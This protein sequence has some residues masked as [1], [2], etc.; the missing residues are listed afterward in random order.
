[1]SAPDIFLCIRILLLL[2]GCSVS[3]T[4][5]LQAWRHINIDDMANKNVLCI[6]E[7]AAGFMYFGTHEGV[8]VFDGRH[9]H[10]VA[11]RGS[12][13]KGIFNPFVNS[14]KWGRGGKLWV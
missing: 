13:Q 8:Q 12:V 14:M 2:T 10:Q 4:A 5:Q 3:A 1:M 9:F 7:D 6:T 11:V